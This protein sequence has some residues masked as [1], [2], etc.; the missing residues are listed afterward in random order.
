MIGWLLILL[1]LFNCAIGFGL[2][3][4]DTPAWVVIVA[5]VAAIL[6]LQLTYLATVVIRFWKG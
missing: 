3:T 2:A 6:A 5:T 4:N 1:I